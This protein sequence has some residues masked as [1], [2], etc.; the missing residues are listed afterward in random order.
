V[1]ATSADTGNVFRFTGRELDAGGLYYYRARYYDPTTGRFVSED[2]IGFQSGMNLYSYVGN[3]PVGRRDPLGLGHP[4]ADGTA[5]FAADMAQ[6]PVA[7]SPNG[8]SGG[9][10]NEGGDHEATDPQGIAEDAAQATRIAK[11]LRRWRRE[12][13]AQVSPWRRLRSAVIGILLSLLML[14][15]EVGATPESV[16][17]AVQGLYRQGH[18]GSLNKNADRQ[19]KEIMRAP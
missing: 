1:D 11:D 13:A 19:L 3:H 18:G 7:G 8:C 4:G 16:C 15:P 12:P 2:P 6:A 5:S 10:K 14:E 17:E 9:S